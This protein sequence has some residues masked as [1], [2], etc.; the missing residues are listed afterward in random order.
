MSLL[1]IPPHKKKTLRKQKVKL[2]INSCR[3]F[4]WHAV[5]GDVDSKFNRNKEIRGKNG[6]IFLI[7]KMV[8]KI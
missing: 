1:P 4:P 3:G 5:P 6:L 8:A 7:L 2:D